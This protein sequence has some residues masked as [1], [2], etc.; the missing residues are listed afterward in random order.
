MRLSFPQ[1]HLAHVMQMVTG[2]LPVPVCAGRNGRSR[3]AAFLDGGRELGSL[4]ILVNWQA[5]G[6][7]Q[8]PPEQSGVADHVLPT[9]NMTSGIARNR[10]ETTGTANACI[11]PTFP[12]GQ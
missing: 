7:A 4:D 1:C 2:L 3:P 11:K 9:G 10:F 5:W 8:S 12:S 6:G